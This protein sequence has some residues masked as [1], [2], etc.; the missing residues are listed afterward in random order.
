[1]IAQEN[2]ERRSSLQSTIVENL[3]HPL[4]L[5]IVLTTIVLLIGYFVVYTPLRDHIASTNHRWSDV[6]SHLELARN[7][8][9]LRSEFRDVEK[10]L[11]HQTDPKE[12]V[13]FFLNSISKLPIE[14]R[15]LQCDSPQDLGPYKAIAFQVDFTA[16]FP[17]LDEFLTWVELNKRFFRVDSIK[18]SA[19]GDKTEPT[20]NVSLNILGIMG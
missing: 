18:I 17:H 3:R 15:S 8:E 9:Q 11:P 4:R 14:L 10:R 6:K 7:L 5:R 12:W 13:Q 2:S 16:T 19:S 1:M 20:L